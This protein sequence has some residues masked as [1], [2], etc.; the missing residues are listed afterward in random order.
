M[1]PNILKLDK[2]KWKHANLAHHFLCMTSYS[3][4]E[5]E[6]EY[7]KYDLTAVLCFWLA[8]HE[9]WSSISSSI[10]SSRLSF[11]LLDQVQCFLSGENSPFSTKKLGKFW[12]NKILVKLWTNN[13]TVKLS[14]NFSTKKMKKITLL[15]LQ[16]SKLTLMWDTFLQGHLLTAGYAIIIN[17]HTKLN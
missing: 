9:D 7:N 2:E 3:P 14:K 8:N 4:A 15:R 1:W 16:K 13:F 17:S 12:E 6:E 10:L 5:E 11:S